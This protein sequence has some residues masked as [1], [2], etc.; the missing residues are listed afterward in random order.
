MS[1]K[2][3]TY[4]DVWDKLSKI[5]CSDK[6]QKKMNLS[7]LSW[8]WAWGV[9]QEHYPQAQ[10]IFY[11]GDNDVP[12]VQFPDGTAEV[13]C[14]VSIDNLSREMWLPV[15]DFKKNAVQN[16]NSMEVNF[17]KMRCL[18]KCLGMYGLG[19]Y[20]YAGEDVPSEDSDTVEK[21]KP[22]KVEPRSVGGSAMTNVQEETKPVEQDDKGYGTEAWAELFVKSFIDL[23]KVHKNKKAM[24][25][26][27][28]SNTKDLATLRDSFPKMK[29]DLDTELKQI[30]SNLEG[31]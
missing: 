5:D 4:K 7:Y 2:E 11:Q 12:Y 21:A 27:Y 25:E 20:I 8:A 28:K 26:Y 23:A 3:L 24:T 17:A 9:L 15:M 30:V 22:K 18:T 13:R 31:E 29:E 10:Y 19:H 14:R 16:P 1:D 6:I